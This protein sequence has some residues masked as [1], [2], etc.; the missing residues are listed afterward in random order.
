MG[1][2]IRP[3]FGEFLVVERLLD[4]YQLFRALQLQDRVPG[5]RLGQC[6]VALGYAPRAVVETLYRRYS[7]EHMPTEAFDRE[8][9]IEIIP[10][11]APLPARLPPP[12][13][14]SAPTAP[15]GIPMIP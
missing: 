10:L 2:E 1:N 13:R 5:A 8:A 6:A 14:S 3:P 12:P 15:A 4:R 11:E 7:L 9:I